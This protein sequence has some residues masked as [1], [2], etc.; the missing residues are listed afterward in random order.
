[1][2][3]NALC[4]FHNSYLSPLDTEAKRLF[5]SLCEIDEKLGFNNEKRK[6]YIICGED[7][8]K[9]MLKTLCNISAIYDKKIPELWIDIL[10]DKLTWPRGWG[11]YLY[12]NVNE[13][14][15][16][17]RL[18]HLKSFDDSKGAIVALEISFY[19]LRFL[20]AVSETYKPK[21]QNL[22]FRPRRLQY[23]R[24]KNLRV[25]EITW[26]SNLHKEVITFQHVGYKTGSP[27]I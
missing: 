3:I 26:Q 2:T 10:C 11:M 4:K 13:D 7:L 24:N 23:E 8:E 9:W 6:I 14:S 25:L 19:G 17:S 12:N 27:P 18:L 22:V 20:L 16:Q 5:A 15:Y 1:M 21:E